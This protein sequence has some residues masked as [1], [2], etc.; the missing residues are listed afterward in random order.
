MTPLDF[1]IYKGNSS[2]NTPCY[3]I[4]EAMKKPIRVFTSDGE[5]KILSYYYS[6]EK[7]C[8]MLD[9]GEDL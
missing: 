9:I 8:F 7:K 1:V 4:A 2:P 5:T 3:L 6:E